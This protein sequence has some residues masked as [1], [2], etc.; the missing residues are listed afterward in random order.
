M[1][2]P[3]VPTMRNHWCPSSVL[4]CF[5]SSLLAFQHHFWWNS[6][7]CSQTEIKSLVCCRWKHY[8]RKTFGSS[9]PCQLSFCSDGSMSWWN[10]QCCHWWIS[11]DLNTFQCLPRPP[12][13]HT[14]ST[15]A[16]SAASP[17]FLSPVSTW[18]APSS[19]YHIYSSVAQNSFSCPLSFPS[20]TPSPS[21]YSWSWPTSQ[22]TDLSK[23]SS[24][25]VHL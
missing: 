2:C 6:S 12:I 17:S 25:I 5:A 13:H 20:A 16:S 7:H 11:P 18:Q 14:R 24:W 21:L 9:R 23:D 22:T 10:H 15:F 3:E 1:A 8:P 19:T 4:Y